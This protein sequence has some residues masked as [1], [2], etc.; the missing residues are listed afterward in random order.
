MLGL[1]VAGALLSLIIFVGRDRSGTVTR[2]LYAPAAGNRHRITVRDID[3]NGTF[4]DRLTGRRFV[5]RGTNYIRLAAQITTAGRHIVYHSTFNVGAYDGSRA[6]AA[7]ARMHGDG[8]DVV[9][10]FL[11][12]A[13]PAA[14]VVDAATGGISSAYVADVVDFLRRARRHHLQVLLT[15][16]RLPGRGRYAELLAGAASSRVQ[17]T[18][19]DFLTR[20]GA[21][22]N[23]EFWQDFVSELDAQH[24]PLDAIFGY[25]LRNELSVADDEPPLTLRT[26]VF[27]TP[28]G[29]TY[30]LAD[31]AARERML[32]SNVVGWIDRVRAAIRRL[33]G[34]ALV[35]VGFAQADP[36]AR[37]VLARSRADFVDVHSYPGVG[38]SLSDLVAG[39]GLTRPLRTPLLMGELGAFR[40]VYPSSAAAA[41][42]LVERQSA[43]CREGFSGWLSWTWD[44]VEQRSLWN[45]LNAQGA[46]ERALSPKL[47]PNACAPPGP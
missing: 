43:S 28:D 34:T 37:A 29:R 13:C 30:A 47:R 25:E 32:T 12:P 7:L 20:G 42:A 6:G 26:G 35:G 11:D 3:G 2:K 19:L 33:D 22:A 15:I 24:A 31:A 4:F 9:R 5:P 1:V 39:I 38:Q 18:N 10:V 27:S 16:D 8:Y 41:R 14:C 40:F 17:S 44:T 36:I 23:V 46:I 45:A 21:D